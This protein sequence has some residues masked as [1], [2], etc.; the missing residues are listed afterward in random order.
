MSS[1]GSTFTLRKCAVAI[2]AIGL[3]PLS[4]TVS[5]QTGGVIEEVRVTGSRIARDPNQT[6]ASPV[7]TVGSDDIRLSGS[8]EAADVL[9]VQPALLTSQ[10]S[11]AS[12]DA[13]GQ[14]GD[15]TRVGQAVLALRGM[16]A[17]RTLTL[18]DGRRH[19]AGIEGSQAVDVG[20]IPSALIER[21]EVLTGGASSIY[22]ADAVTGVVNFIL[23]SDFEGL[24]VDARVSMDDSGQGR[25][26]NLSM[27][28]GQNFQDGRGNF[29]VGLDVLQRKHITFGDKGHTRDNNVAADRVNPARRFQDGDLSAADTPHF[30][31]FFSVDEGR[32]PY[33]FPIP[34]SDGD[35]D[36]FAA[37]YE[38]AF[39]EAPEFTAAELALI[40][41]AAT[42][43]PR[44]LMSQAATFIASERGVLAPGNFDPNTP[45]DLNGN[46][47]PDCLESF[48]GSRVGG[49]LGGC[50]SVEADGARPFQEG[51]IS[52]NLRGFGGD[53]VINSDRQYSTPEE[54]KWVLNVTGRY[55]LTQRTRLFGEAKYVRHDSEFG[56]GT[57]AFFD[58]LR[59]EP[60][61]AF[62]PPEF[63]PFAE[64]L[65]GYFITRDP[66]DLGPNINK[67][68]RET[69]RFVAGIE[70]EFDNGMYYEASANFGRF[71]RSFRNRERPIFDRYFA[72]IDAV[73]DPV[74][75]EPIC[76]SDIDP[77]R[78]PFTTRFN[79]PPFSPGF[80]T[81]NPGDGQCRPINLFG[82]Q[83][84][85][86]EAIDFVSTTT[87][88]DFRL[89][90]LSLL[91]TLA[92]EIR[93]LRL[94]G[95]TV[96]FAVGAEYRDESSRSRFDPLARGV[97]PVDTP[98][99][100]AGQLVRNLGLAQN[101]LVHN[102]R[103]IFNDSSS[104]YDVYE[105]FFEFSLPLLSDAR[106][107]RELTLDASYRFSDY[108]TVGST[109]SYGFGLAWAPIDDV[110]LRGSLSRAVRAPNITELFSPAEA[111][112]FGPGIEPC[113][114][115][116]I[117]ALLD[118][119][120]PS[121]PIRQANCAAELG[122]D[123]TNPLSAS[124]GGA[125]EGNP[126]LQEET[127]DT[128]TIGVAFHPRF[129][130]GLTLHADY[131]NVQIDDAIESISGADI[132]KNCYDSPNFPDNTFCG[133]IE[134]NPDASSQQ[135]QGLT[136][137][138]QSPINFG[139][140]ESSGV[141]FGAS[142]LF[143][144]LGGEFTANL[145][146]TWV[147]ELNFFFDPTDA[148]AVDPQ[149]G[150]IQRPKWAATGNLAY[151]RGPMNL[152]WT[153][154]YQTSQFLRGV[155]ARNG[156]ELYGDMA[157]SGSSH[158]HDLA[159]SYDFPRWQLYGGVNNVLDRKPFATERAWPV[160]PRGRV[161]FL[162]FNMML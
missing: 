128:Y 18:V 150:A 111:V 135:F 61:N 46:G 30:S 159:A 75:G 15:P 122:A 3:L 138:R 83:G 4:A 60:D 56:G 158:V 115:A 117:N 141:D 6:S 53:G 49:I 24:D 100:A 110:R 102:P 93:Q 136:F 12:A 147:R 52:D 54:L 92:G 94:P 106:F 63:Q 151:R 50:W 65:D 11:E 118:A 59:I 71:D 105:L 91:A 45:I 129:L 35:V 109:H 58:L 101:S 103:N 40:E 67:N 116:E 68:T 143:N 5:A 69:M 99:A 89:E 155:S 27:L 152:R 145:N 133:L 41:R 97:I 112:T 90:Q 43:P 39:G 23:K 130:D 107:A 21:V 14:G 146:G 44:A 137:I 38:Q 85:S 32:F 73:P 108:S 132:L 7:Q 51:L 1:T 33:G 82:P 114:P 17:S 20:T 134:R 125:I 62:I 74:T 162:G 88:D 78:R 84:A 19:V 153:T 10:S 148:S 119:G 29:T 80:F 98:D 127:A 156:R 161:L 31:R 8:S 72:A 154:H 86:P 160:T 123:F 66:L 64:Q 81:F 26:S 139:A 13:G 149:L 157:R 104:G 22:G 16:G 142:Y 120:D 47:I 79:I 57:H 2:A 9:R 76:R 113:E 140:V 42:A 55:D 124:F 96:G 131:W 34:R 87:V 95:G 37:Q 121:G 144:G 36:N 48:Q 70:G 126:A 77:D 28:F 25:T